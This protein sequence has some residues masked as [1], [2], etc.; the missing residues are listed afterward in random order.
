[1]SHSS[2]YQSLTEKSEKIIILLPDGSLQDWQSLQN[3]PKFRKFFPW[4]NRSGQ[5]ERN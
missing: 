4:S 1:M 2:K 5:T 3:D